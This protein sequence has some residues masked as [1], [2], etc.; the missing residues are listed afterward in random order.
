[1]KKS[2]L[3]GSACLLAVIPLF[4]SCV[5][6]FGSED[7][8][9]A[10]PIRFSSKISKE[11]TT[12]VT[13][14]LFEEGDQV[15]LFA[16]LNSGTL[17]GKRYI[18]NATLTYTDASTFTPSET[19]YY[20]SGKDKLDF[21]AYYPY[22][23][24]GVSE[25][26]TTLSVAVQ[27]DQQ[28]DAAH[29]QSD[30]LVASKSGVSSSNTPVKLSFSH[31]F[32]KLTVVLVPQEG[33][34]ASEMLAANPRIVATGL[35]TVCTY[36]LQTAAVSS[37]SV[38]ADMLPYGSWATKKSN[39][40]GK[41]FIIVPQQISPTTQAFL[42]EWNGRLYT[43]PMPSF[44][45]VGGTRYEIQIEAK[46]GSEES[47][48]PG[49]VGEID[50]WTTGEKIDDTTNDYNSTAVHLSALSFSQSDVYRAYSNGVAVADICKE[51]LYSNTLT[52]RAI[53]A[54][55]VVNNVTDL[56][57]G[58]LLQLLDVSGVKVG[59]TL[60]WNINTNLF[61]YAEGSY[62]SI[63][64]FFF[65]QQN[66]ITLEPPT[67]PHAVN[68]AAYRLKDIRKEEVISYPIVKVGVQYWTKEDLRTT[69]YHDGTPI[70]QKEELGAYPAYFKP[71]DK[72]YYFYN[73]E[74]LLAKEMAPDGW[75]IP[76][77]D[78]WGVLKTY[79]NG[80]AALVKG[81]VWIA[82]SQTTPVAPVSNLT[83][84]SIL[85]QGF[86]Y[87]NTGYGGEQYAA[88]YW[89]MDEGAIPEETPNFYGSTSSFYSANTKPKDV[90]AYY[91]AF[92]IRLLKK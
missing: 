12:R 44:D 59:G 8:E 49:F 33:E 73:G 68:I 83:G 61:T 66:E 10:V 21:I 70:A 35:N 39:L 29:S 91:K 43:C 71:E 48:L 89:T 88:G 53:V 26:S 81:G 41:E 22:L 19:L 31:Q 64:Q 5:N 86:W 15:G 65:N 85:P 16:M 72:P 78:D 30:F 69:R 13:A 79:V 62:N 63:D 14:N 24:E 84:L 50:D 57:K 90:A 3:K 60:S 25:G 55:P 38:P 11:A 56:T 45:A 82:S 37:T 6:H 2:I 52:S 20:P 42:L 80:T 54:Y 51:Y 76:S 77:S 92:S 4:I 9:E 47:V 28:T 1:M 34:T 67:K 58:T 32:A 7:E 27:T 23:S 75:R 36:N 87:D 17:D 18:D 74:A 46:Q 40:T